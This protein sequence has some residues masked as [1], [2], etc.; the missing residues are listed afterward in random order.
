[1]FP[2]KPGHASRRIEND[3][4]VRDVIAMIRMNYDRIV[5][6]FG[7]PAEREDERVA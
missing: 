3:D 1:V 5:D 4:D 6:R 2:G 7:L